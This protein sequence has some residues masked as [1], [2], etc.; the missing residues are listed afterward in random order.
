M[1][2]SLMTWYTALG[3]LDEA[4]AIAEESLEQAQAADASGV[5]WGGLWVE[6]MRTFRQDPRFPGLM[7]RL[8]F[9]PYWKANR[10]PTD[11][12]IAGDS[13]VCK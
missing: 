8:H 13:L 3:A 10:P 6:S 2:H 7:A 11:C 4:Y 9:L 12:E 5:S 1:S